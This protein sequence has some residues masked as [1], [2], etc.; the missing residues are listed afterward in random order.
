MFLLTRPS[1]EWIKR[2]IA[3]QQRC[4]FSYRETGAS[5]QAAPAD[6]TVDRNQ[7]KL[8]KGAATFARAVEAVKR[9]EMFNLGWVN[10]C[11]PYAPIAEGSVVAVLASHFGFW[12]LS[13]CRIVYVIDE[14]GPVRR[15]GFAYGTLPDHAERGEE[16]F[17][18][19]WRTE[20][21]SVW[22]DIL[23]FSQP[24][25]VLA[26]IGYPI[27]RMLQKRF[28]RMSKEAMFKYVNSRAES[29]SAKEGI[30]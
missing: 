20:D 17:S 3:S 15:F 28:A 30:Q 24:N 5:R 8:G 6:Y 1:E 22:Y 29:L 7:I 13:A 11:W 4:D 9:W 26:K 12:S 14:D 23:A 19:E 21:D 2:F 18:I 16:R 27:T 10:L 25:Q